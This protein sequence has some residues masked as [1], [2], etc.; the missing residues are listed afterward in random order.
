[1]MVIGPGSEITLHFS[2][3]LASGALID[4]TPKGKPGTFEFGDETLPE[5][6]ESLL[7][8]LKA[9]DRRSFV[10]PAKK[11]FG[12][13]RQQNVQRFKLCSLQ[14]VSDEPLSNGLTITFKDKSGHTVSG[15]VS[16]MPDQDLAEIPPETLIDVDFNHPL[17]GRDL[18]FS[19]EIVDVKPVAQVVQLQSVQDQGI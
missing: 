1:M 10:V 5:G 7:R 2:L 9:G 3:A 11:A 16:Q 13:W 12:E 4:A 19:V 6:F 17:A 14:E 8:G 15:V 18:S